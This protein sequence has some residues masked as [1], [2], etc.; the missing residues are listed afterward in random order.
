MYLLFTDYSCLDEAIQKAISDVSKDILEAMDD[1][2][3]HGDND[4][5]GYQD[6]GRRRHAVTP[7]G[8]SRLRGVHPLFATCDHSIHMSTATFNRITVGVCISIREPKEVVVGELSLKNGWVP[9]LRLQTVRD[10]RMSVAFVDMDRL[11]VMV[12]D[13]ARPDGVDLHVINKNY[14]VRSEHVT[15]AHFPTAIKIWRPNSDAPHHLAISNSPDPYHSRASLRNETTFYKWTGTYFDVYTSVD[16]YKVSDVCP[17][18]SGGKD[19]VVIIN[20]ESAPNI[21]EVDSELF[22]YDIDNKKWLSV[23]KIR[24]TGVYYYES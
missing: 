14:A 9:R 20:Y 11:F 6:D 3:A 21:F 7:D 23:Q 2:P 13:A 10:P 17:F 12:A 18:S 1:Q 22:R 8:I 5:E 19:Y 4:D 15:S 24:T 16:S